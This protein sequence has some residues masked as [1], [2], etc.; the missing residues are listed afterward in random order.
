[1]KKILVA[2]LGLSAAACDCGENAKKIA[3]A[4]EVLTDDGTAERTSVDF[5]FVQ[6]NLKGTQ[7]VRVH[8]SG[9]GQLTINNPSA[10][11]SQFGL[12]NMLPLAVDPG[13]DGQL[14][15]TFTPTVPDQRV[16]GT[17]TL[18]SNDP[19]RDSFVLML[20]GQGV[21]AVARP[22]PA[23]LAFGDVYVGESSTKMLT[24]TNAGGNALPV[25]GASITGMPNGVS[26]DFTSLTNVMIAPGGSATVPV[27]FA[28]MVGGLIGSVTGAVVIQ[29][30]AAFGGNVTVPLTGR[31]TQALPRMCFKFDDSATE[32]CTDQVTTNLNVS[33]G[34]LCDN[35]LYSCPGSTGQRTGKL[36]FKNEG[37]VPVSFSAM[38]K[39]YIYPGVRCGADAGVL[40]DF[41]FSNVVVPDG[42]V[43]A[44]FNMATTSL[45]M[46]ESDPMPW[47][48]APIS[49]TYRAASQCL[50]EGA[51][52]AQI[53]WTRQGPLGRNP[54]TLFATLTGTSLLPNAKPKPVNLGQ[55]LQPYEVPS[56]TPVP[57]ELVT[58]Q[59]AA[60]LTLTSVEMWEELPAYLPD[61]GTYDGG[62]PEGGILSLCNP[63][64]PTYQDSDCARFQWA[65]GQSPGQY[66]PATL[67]G[68]ATASNPTLTTVGK[69]FVGCINDGGDCPPAT[70]RY[71][72][73]A[74]VNTSDPYA[75]RI[76]VPIIAYVRLK[77]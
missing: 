37:N 56:P 36:Y 18:S 42:G 71:K 13:E 49:I 22:T 28:P 6:V 25:T 14:L 53:L 1:V 72:V 54:S 58:N 31:A 19:K 66:L 61:G 3:P 65:P 7:K 55:A 76:A 16:T 45:P 40:S 74:I 23:M 63:A 43:P 70:T 68:G 32:T 51:D 38:Y 8:N 62:G 5:G 67:D 47:E 24:L 21:T 26:G 41:V 20:A 57:V 35:R 33:F 29:I 34:A 75:S 11:P 73:I 2:M 15:T 48:T 69:L 46:A 39:P 44:P 10:M 64:S 27:T 60:P 4:L 30:D 52:Q 50:D 9:T 17:L 77:P 12:D 59:G